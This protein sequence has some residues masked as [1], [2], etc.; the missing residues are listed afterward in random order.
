MKFSAS[1][2]Y[3]SDENQI[4]MSF[5]IILYLSSNQKSNTS[6]EFSF[7]SFTALQD[8]SIS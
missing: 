3:L 6:L 7:G 1:K 2:A 5:L 8:G 4:S